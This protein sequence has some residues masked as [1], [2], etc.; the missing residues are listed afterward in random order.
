MLIKRLLLGVAVVLGIAVTSFNPPVALILAA[1]VWIYLV[2]M[3]SQ[4]ENTAL[5]DQLEPAMTERHL[6][7]LKALLGVAGFAFLVSIAS[8]VVHNVSPDLFGLEE[9]VSL[10]VALAAIWVSVI[11]TAAGMVLFLKERQRAT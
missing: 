3:V 6:K 4:H 8:A 7:N 2:R 10:L 5:G 11:A 9:I 1:G